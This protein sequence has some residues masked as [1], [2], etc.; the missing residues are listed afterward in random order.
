MEYLRNIGSA[1]VSALVQKSG[2]NLPFSLGPKVA[3]YETLWTLYDAKK[4]VGWNPT[5][6]NVYIR[7]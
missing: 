3:N 2:I 7:F 6:I 4:R 1:A 5:I